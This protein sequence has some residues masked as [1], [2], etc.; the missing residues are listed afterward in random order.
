[1]NKSRFLASPAGAYLGLL[2]TFV[3]W[4]SLYVVTKLLFN[5]LPVFT[6]AFLR[7]SL[8]YLALLAYSRVIREPAA[9][10]GDREYLRAVL[11]QGVGGYAI[12]V[13]LQLLGTRF[14]GSTMA[15][16]INSLNPVTISLLAV[17]ILHEPLTARKA[18]GIAL[19]VFGVYLIV[20][21]G[22]Q[23]VSPLGIAF[24]LM[25]VAGWSLVSVLNRG[26]IARYGALNVTRDAIGVTALC[27]LIFCAIECA[28]TRQVVIP[29]PGAWLGLIYLA[30]FCTGL[31]YI[32]WNLSLS[33]LPASTCSAFYP[34]Q[35]LT[36]ALLGI[37]I[38]GERLT[39]S[40][41]AGAA[42]IVCGILICLLQKNKARR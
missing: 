20:G 40:F 18:F 1:M 23:Q 33:V 29:T 39:W 31:T 2:L 12:S 10:K 15:S 24:S 13:G 9:P 11:L 27:N 38:F 26:R 5:S 25:S 34:L 36:S 22:T 17:L 21:L 3:L 35:P 28:V 4:G 30:V 8:A 7:F 41:A 37:L 32:L 19:A 6:T 14:A 42:C 16:L